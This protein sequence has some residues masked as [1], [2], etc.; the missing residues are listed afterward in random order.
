MARYNKKKDFVDSPLNPIELQRKAKTAAEIRKQNKENTTPKSAKSVLNFQ[1]E[2]SQIFK[3]KTINLSDGQGIDIINNNKVNPIGG[4]QIEDK[5]ITNLVHQLQS[6]GFYDV[7]SGLINR[8]DVSNTFSWSNQ[9]VGLTASLTDIKRKHEKLKEFKKNPGGRHLYIYDTETIGG[10]NS[11]GIWNPSGITEFSMRD[12]N[13][14]TNKVKNTNIVLGIQET[15]ENK[16][17]YDD[18]VKLLEKGDIDAIMANEQYRVTASRAALYSHKNTVVKLDPNKG[19]YV[20][21]SLSD[22]NAEDFL[23]LENFKE[24]WQKLKHVHDT[25]PVNDKG[26]KKSIAAFM[27]ATAEMHNMSKLDKG[28]VIG[29]NHGPFDMRVMN[30][31]MSRIMYGYKMAANETIDRTYRDLLGVTSSQAKDIITEYEKMF[32]GQVGFSVPTDNF[33]DSL[34][35]F[36]AVKNAFGT[37]ALLNNDADIIKKAKGKTSGQEFIGEAWFKDRFEDGIA[38]MADFDTLILEDVF[39]RKIDVNN[40]SYESL[41]DYL[42]E[43]VGGVGLQGLT[44][45]NKKI[46]PGEQLFYARKGSRRDFQGKGMF[47][48]T[49]NAVTGEVYTTSN[50]KMNLDNLSPAVKDNFYMGTEINQGQFYTIEGIKKINTKDLPEDLG[51]LVPELSGPELY[52]VHMKLAVGNNAGKGYDD[53]LYVQNF[54][55]QDDVAAFISNLTMV[56]E[57]GPD[58]WKITNNKEA[59]D[60]LEIGVVQDGMIGIIGNKFDDNDLVTLATTKSSNTLASDRFRNK[61]LRGDKAYHNTKKFLKAHQYITEKFGEDADAEDIVRLL[62]EKPKDFQDKELQEAARWL[63]DLYGFKDKKTNS[64]KISSNTARPAGTAYEYMT[65]RLEF[66]KAV[67]KEVS[68]YST[69]N[70][71]TFA[72]QNELFLQVVETAQAKI[73]EEIYTNDPDKLLRAATNSSISHDTVYNLKQKYE[74]RIPEE[75]VLERSKVNQVRT[76]TNIHDYSD[77]ITVNTKKNNEQFTLI[78]Q[79]V[80]KRYG[81]LDLS[82]NP[83]AYQRDAV[84]SFIRILTKSEDFDINDN[85]YLAKA[86]KEITENAKDFNVSNTAADVVK[87]MEYEKTKNI[88]KGIIK[89]SNIFSLEVVDADFNKALNAIGDRQT[90]E[91]FIGN[92]IANTNRKKDITK[93]N[94]KELMNFVKTNLLGHYMPSRTEYEEAIKDL[95]KIQKTHKTILYNKVEEDVANQIFDVLKAGSIVPNG[96]LTIDGKGQIGFKLNGNAIEFDHITKIHLDKQSLVAQVGNQEFSVMNA[97]DWDRNGNAFVTT[98]LGELT[99]SNKSITRRVERDLKNNEFDISTFG[100]YAKKVSKDMLEQA[101]YE[102]TP[103]DHFANYKVQTKNLHKLLPELFTDNGSLRHIGA[104]MDL[105]DEVK[106][107]LNK[108][109][110][111]KTLE[112]GDL[113]PAVFNLISSYWPQIVRETSQSGSMDARFIASHLNSASKDKSNFS[114]GIMMGADLRFETGLMNAFSNGGRPQHTAAGHTYFIASETVQAVADKAETLFYKG[115]LFESAQD[116]IVNYAN[117]SGL[118]ELT[119]TFTARTLYTGQAGIEALLDTNMD[120]VL[121][122]N[123]WDFMTMDK[124]RKVYN[125]GYYLM[126][127]FEQQK[128][129]NA[130]MFDELTGGTIAANVQTLSKGKDFINIGLPEN[131]KDSKALNAKYERLYNLLGSVTMSPEG[132]LEYKSSVGEIL[133]HGE[134]VIPYAQFGGGTNNWVNKM[135]HG[136]LEF[137][138]RSEEGVRFS[139][140]QIS[141]LLNKHQGMFKGVDMSDHKAVLDRAMDIFEKEG[142]KAAY[143]IEDINKTNLPKIL[144]DESE[145]SMNHLTRIKMGYLNDDIAKVM[146]AYGGIPQ[147]LIGAVTPTPQAFKAMFKDEERLLKALKEGGFKTIDELWEAAQEESYVLS[148]MLFGKKGV[149][150]GIAAIGNDNISG[151]GN[152]GTMMVGSINEM[153]AM[154]GKYSS[155]EKVENSKTRELGLEKFVELYN[156]KY[157]FFKPAREVGVD[158][159]TQGKK[160]FNVNGHLMFE[161]GEL[162]DQSINGDTV[163]TDTLEAMFRD[164]DEWLEKQGAPMEDRFVHTRTIKYGKNAGETEE[165]IGRFKYVG[166]KDN[167]MLPIGAAGNRIVIDPETQ[168]GMTSDYVDVLKQIKQLKAERQQYIDKV[169][170][171][172]DGDYMAQLMVDDY[173]SKIDVLKGKV[174]D[175]EETGHLM[176]LGDQEL[177]ILRSSYTID[178]DMAEENL[179][180]LLKDADPIRRKEIEEAAEAIGVL[181]D[182]G[183]E[184]QVFKFLRDQLTEQKYYNPLTDDLLTEDMLKSDEYKHLAEVYDTFYQKGLGKELGVESAQQMYDL[185]SVMA[186]KNFNNLE[187]FID[188]D[189]HPIKLGVDDM[190]KMGFETMNPSEYLNTFGSGSSAT[191]DSMVKKNVLLELGDEFG[192]RKYVAIPGMGI[193]LPDGEVKRDWHK[194]ASRLVDQYEDYQAAHGNEQLVPQLKENILNTLDELDSSLNKFANKKSNLHKIAQQEIFVATDRNKILTTINTSKNP[195]LQQATFEGKTLAEL[196]EQGIHIDYSFDSLE[197]FQKRGFFDKEYLDKLN[198]TREEMIEHLKTKGTT[199]VDTRYPLIIDYSKV[200][201]RHYLNDTV[202][203]PNAALISPITALKMNADSDGDS[204]SRFMVEHKGVN[205]LEYELAREKTISKMGGMTFDSREAREAFIR[206]QTIASGFDEEVYDTF[207]R[208]DV[209]MAQNAVGINVLYNQKV[210]DKMLEDNEKV[211]SAQAISRGGKSLVS[212]VEGGESVLGHITLSTLAKDPTFTQ[213]SENEQLVNQM[214]GIVRA[215]GDLLADKSKYSELFGDAD[216]IL[217][218]KNEGKALD[219]ALVAM[220]ELKDMNLSSLGIDDLVMEGAQNAAIERLKIGSYM[221]EAMSKSGIAATGNVNSTLYGITQTAKAFYGNP[222]MEDMYDP[223]KSKIISKVAHE[224]EQAPISSKKVAIKAG[225]DRLI[226]FGDIFSRIKRNGLEHSA[227]QGEYTNRELLHN[228][229]TDFIDEKKLAGKFDE[230][231]YEVSGLGEQLNLKT[232]TE[233]AQYM[234]NQYIDISGQLLDK[235]ASPQTRS[236]IDSFGKFGRR[237]DYSDIIES[238]VGMFDTSSTMMGGAIE[239][240]TWQKT[241]RSQHANVFQSIANEQKMAGSTTK[242]AMNDA[243]ENLVNRQTV[244]ALSEAVGNN[245]SR[246][247]MNNSGSIGKSLGLGVVG[248][249]AGLLVAG[250]ASGNPLNDANAETI[251]QETQK[252]PPL[253]FGSTPPPEM[254]PNNTGGYIININGN[255]KK[256][257]RQLKHAL[258]QVANNSVGGGVNVNMNIKTSKSGGYSDRDIENVLNDYF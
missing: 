133:K 232:T 142:L 224:F 194:I 188:P 22:A 140:K 85:P 78:K 110:T 45:D 175:L 170:S 107:R 187:S 201:S 7:Y 62:T 32:G 162:F 226:D 164:V 244:D 217:A 92:I 67:T 161:N 231:T 219:Q 11:S 15:P 190:K 174:R 53:V 123:N 95:G 144:I 126:N 35:I 145:K 233:K 44:F 122:E 253:D 167:T 81:D 114:K 221:S 220:Q 235:K 156:D 87:A 203:A 83:E 245:I 121:K 112:P 166:D 23:N 213:V 176:R 153:V 146:D 40:K 228:W 184:K 200:P 68:E 63:Q 223:L 225:D 238:A 149:L 136:L 179:E 218:M 159:K 52:Q 243:A 216:N 128:V 165:L 138:V 204:V 43:D 189:G 127:T 39:T 180:K 191:Y 211:L 84:A 227:V 9:Q 215:S 240:A 154:L 74:F 80:K 88:S 48:Y 148:E 104:Q 60:I 143:T 205:H 108:K 158:P 209:N 255:T 51:R 8:E 125:M 76:M 106:E 229:M 17:L 155:A 6:R 57:G 27:E 50:Y 119:S 37:E 251:T 13:L 24:G 82:Q 109:L 36:N 75:F 105:P 86:A 1:E 257:N 157:Q 97:L 89:E 71:L 113:D 181:D 178:K 90:K 129:F 139:D 55:S 91:N 38:H 77:V 100:R 131:I 124:K 4:L 195:L 256:G 31:E 33:L 198:M 10:T 237:G 177:G 26:V 101:G 193:E 132:V 241:A 234:I 116:K 21:E 171:S 160:L 93:M 115:A 212:A 69:K 3:P 247:V 5:K 118:G 46:K 70:N 117:V 163:D 61:Y 98:N 230:L 99:H 246:M 199:M 169:K 206:E 130:K 252:N 207:K 250:Y 236:M 42:M 94:D 185:R 120:K 19:Y 186:A 16:K 197:A 208:V 25:T 47:N 65:D 196:T 29:Q 168:S 72:E 258:K 239:M 58:K 152:K 54:A 96:E 111:G 151:H 248:L 30:T 141:E 254:V 147:E 192:S 135:N 28:M 222:D 214:I 79:L 137:T 150:P 34:P 18:I 64:T 49:V 134:D 66:Y 103:G 172:P 242:K 12:I 210:V 14:E 182:T 2:L 73:A 173:N 20:M 56:A 41:F 102:Y 202:Q 59:R 183:E 249:A